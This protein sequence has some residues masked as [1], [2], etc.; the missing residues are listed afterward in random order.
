MCGR[1][2]PN[3][4]QCIANNIDNLKDKLC[5][6]IPELGVPPGNPYTLDELRISDTPNTKVYVRDLKVTGICDFV[7]NFLHTDLDRLHFDIKL[8]FKQ[9]QV[10]TTYDFNI[11]LL[12]PIAYKGLVYITIGM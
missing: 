9:I 12:V 11:H 2:D 10:N 5:D 6:G 3:L 1:R 8:L 4:D 7:V